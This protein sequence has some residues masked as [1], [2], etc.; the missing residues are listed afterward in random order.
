MKQKNN[1]NVNKELKSAT[2]QIVDIKI[3]LYLVSAFIIMAAAFVIDLLRGT[4]LWIYGKAR[5]M[6]IHINLA[7][8]EAAREIK[9]LI[10]NSS[11]QFFDIII[12]LDTILA[13]AVIF[14]YSVQDSRKEGIPHRTI[15]AYTFGSF[16]VPIL[17]VISMLMLP[18]SF[19]AL[20]L[21]LGWF[22][23]TGMIFTYITHVIIIILILLSTSYQY[24]VHA[25]GNAEI[26]QYQKLCSMELRRQEQEYKEKEKVEQNPS[27]IWTYLL[28]HLE[29]VVLSDELIADKL[30]LIRRLIRAP[31][32]RNVV[33]LKEEYTLPFGK[34]LK[35]RGN[36]GPRISIE[37]L[38]DNN[39]A[40]IYEFYYQN[41]ISFF[42]HIN[43]LE[44]LEERKI[45]YIVLYEFMEELTELYEKVKQEEKEEKVLGNCRKNYL[46]TICGI[47]N[48]VMESN[49]DDAEG[50]CNYVF[51]HIVCDSE[52]GLQIDF[53]FLFQEY[54]YRTNPNAI[55]LKLLEEVYGLGRW[56][57][58]SAETEVYEKFWG[59]W[60]K[61][62]TL[63]KKNRYLYFRKAF[64]TLK[65]ETC[66]SEPI[67]YIRMAVQKQKVEYKYEHEKKYESKSDKTGK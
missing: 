22:A 21:N 28:H 2:R 47:L 15:M 66:E 60:T 23:W 8:Y 6:L 65:K 49:A 20:F 26:K 38:K 4:K 27:F 35:K 58:P 12:T 24:S 37:K 30:E 56:D 32:Y 40:K 44:N 34:K 17:F 51:N 36:K 52:W 19:F 3:I 64:R 9:V 1:I 31:Y 13:A 41:L 5:D 16:T 18:V 53:Y 63:S 61:F 10:E 59:V 33:K 45:I 7:W 46:M 62:T 29:Q 39:L 54:L 57:G 11:G 43:C 48:P 42:R 67:T 25:I 55:K 50:F 14:F